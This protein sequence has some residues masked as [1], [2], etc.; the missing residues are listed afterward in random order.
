MPGYSFVR[1]SFESVLVLGLEVLVLG[2]DVLGLG[3]LKLCNE[4]KRTAIVL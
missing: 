4:A 3:V 1:L 2:L